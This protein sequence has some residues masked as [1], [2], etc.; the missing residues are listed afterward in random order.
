M[1]KKELLS[2]QKQALEEYKIKIDFA[3]KNKPCKY[4]N[5]NFGLALEIQNNFKN[6]YLKPYHKEHGGD[7]KDL[8]D[9]FIWIPFQ[10]I[11]QEKQNL[12]K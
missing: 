7:W 3:F 9:N 8:F 4:D 12:Y 2:A 10:T 6:K 5:H 11:Y 1:T